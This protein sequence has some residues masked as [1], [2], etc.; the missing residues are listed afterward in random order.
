MSGLSI[1]EM[2][3]VPTSAFE[4]FQATMLAALTG[5]RD[6]LLR[7]QSK[8]DVVLQGM[9]ETRPFTAAELME[10]LKIPG[11]T[12]EARLDNLA[13]RCKAWGLQRMKGTR[14]MEALYCRADV[15]HAEAWA[16]G[17]TQRR[18]HAA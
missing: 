1:A 17:K 15:L 2:A 7:V 6:E 5:T 4:Q 14:G 18:R 9:D 3:D 10:R 11:E 13:A 8:L 12:Q 16:A